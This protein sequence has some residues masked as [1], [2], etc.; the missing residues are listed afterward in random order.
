M[1]LSRLPFPSSAL[2]PAFSGSLLSVL[3][4]PPS[5]PTI[6][7]AAAWVLER[8]EASPPQSLFRD[9]PK[10]LLGIILAVGKLKNYWWNNLLGPESGFLQMQWQD[11]CLSGDLIRRWPRKHLVLLLL[12]QLP[13][14]NTAFWLGCWAAYWEWGCVWKAVG[15]TGWLTS[16]QKPGLT[17]VGGRG[18]KFSPGTPNY[19]PA[20]NSAVSL[21]GLPFLP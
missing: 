15:K 6:L 10:C 16:A 17:P 12:S 13:G 21:G 18:S 9:G 14:A 11:Y 8:S 3:P 1:S 20:Q 7:M 4:A 5:P 2:S 19:D